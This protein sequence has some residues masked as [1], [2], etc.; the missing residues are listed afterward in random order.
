MDPAARTTRS[1]PDTRRREREA[2]T[3]FWADPDHS[4]CAERASGT[5]AALARHWS[6]VAHS[7]ARGTRVLDLGCGAGIVGC[8]LLDARP[9]LRVTGI[10][11]ARVPAS[12]RRSLDLL[13]GVAMEALPFGG[14]RFGAIVSQFGLEYGDVVATTREIA[15]VAESGAR[16]AFVVHHARSPVVADTRSRLRALRH[17]LAQSLRTSFCSGDAPALAARLAELRDRHPRDA[18]I[19][20]LARELPARIRGARAHRSVIWNELE[21][22]LAPEQCIAECLDESCV[23]P[24]RLDEWLEPLCGA[25]NLGSVVELRDGAGAPVAWRILGNLR[26]QAAST[27]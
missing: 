25:C 26:E 18:L 19:E 9:D 15:R 24:S 10:D 12:D 4:R 27:S 13:S 16:L 7:L 21:E 14:R 5:W 3:K 8:L 6:G 23:P 1:I 22:A 20:L 11:A 17:F 2:W